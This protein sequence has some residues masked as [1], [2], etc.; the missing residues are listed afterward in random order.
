MKPDR[1]RDFARV[2]MMR[3]VPSRPK[4]FRN[5]RDLCAQHSPVLL[6]EKE[7]HEGLYPASVGRVFVGEMPQQ[8]RFFLPEFNPKPGTQEEKTEP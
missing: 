3:D 2:K 4:C 8:E 1:H 6:S 7:W 5:L